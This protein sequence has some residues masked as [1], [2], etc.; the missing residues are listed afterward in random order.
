MGSMIEKLGTFVI[1]GFDW[2]LVAL[3]HAATR[4]RIAGQQR[5]SAMNTMP[6]SFFP[7]NLA[8]ENL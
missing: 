3:C 4:N 5:K 2:H 8:S 1:S 7:N 6:T